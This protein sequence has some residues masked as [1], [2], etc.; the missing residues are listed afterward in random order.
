MSKNRL[1]KGI[2]NVF[3]RAKGTIGKLQGLPIA[4]PNLPRLANPRTPNV[5]NTIA[6]PGRINLQVP[7]VSAENVNYNL[8][9]ETSNTSNTNKRISAEQI[10]NAV[11]TAAQAASAIIPMFKG[12]E[13][14]SLSTDN[15]NENAPKY[16]PLLPPIVA[17][18]WYKTTPGII[19][20]GVGALALL[21]GGIYLMRSGK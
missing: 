19:G 1:S 6:A 20:I 12:G 16:S 15:S 9:A 21:G 7:A 17:V 11:G 18:P 5:L 10:I 8:P 4:R 13:S 14:V 2:S 3:N